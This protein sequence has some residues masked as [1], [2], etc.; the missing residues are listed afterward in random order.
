MSLKIYLYL[1]KIVLLLYEMYV[2][3][4]LTVLEFQYLPKCLPAEQ[5]IINILSVH[6]FLFKRNRYPAVVYY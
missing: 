5:Q 6:H 1:V 2:Q 4:Y 3:K